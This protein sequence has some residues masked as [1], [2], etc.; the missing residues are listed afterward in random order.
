MTLKKFNFNVL[1]NENYAR[2]GLIET[3]R[4]NINTPAFMPVGTQASV[5]SVFID[6]IV[7]TGSEIILGN[8]YH[9]ML[10]PG[11]ERISSLGGLH[12]FMNCNLPILSISL[13]RLSASLKIKRCS[14][15]SK[16]VKIPGSN[17]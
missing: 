8:T 2:V 3:K 11:V 10:R 13:L 1:N 6:D 7:K 5:K 4:G 12:K 9:L 15:H 17:I 14:R 16:L